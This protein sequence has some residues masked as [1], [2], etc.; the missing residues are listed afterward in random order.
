[1][2]DHPNQ[3]K[4]NADLE[5]SKLRS[6]EESIRAFVRAADPKFRQVVPM[7]NGNLTLM[8][9]EADAY[10]ADHLDEK[11]FRADNAR[12]LVRA[13]AII[14]RIGTELTDFRSKQSAQYLWKPHADSLTFLVISAGKLQESAAP[15]VALAK[16]R[17]LI[18]KMNFLNDT[19]K[20][21]RDK[22]TLVAE[23]LETIPH[24]D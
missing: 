11:S 20:R 12:S 24:R 17:G 16:Q 1:M 7:R 22:C 13:V 18:E 3:L 9:H 5:E 23:T 21:L 10:C 6:V 2:S 15:V 8:P 14:A 19:L 4:A